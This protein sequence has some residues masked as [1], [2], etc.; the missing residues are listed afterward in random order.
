MRNGLAMT[1]PFHPKA[2]SNPS[3]DAKI[4]VLLC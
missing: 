1:V 4:L 2:L 3:P